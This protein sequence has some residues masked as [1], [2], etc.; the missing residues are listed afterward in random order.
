MK[1]VSLQFQ[2]LLE[3]VNFTILIGVVNYEVNRTA[4]Q[5]TCEMSDVDLDRAQES[6]RAQIISVSETTPSAFNSFRS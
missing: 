4:F 3:L 5:L 1:K 2:S 6:Y